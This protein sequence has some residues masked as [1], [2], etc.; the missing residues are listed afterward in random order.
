R[1]RHPLA[2]SR[3][4]GC[5]NWDGQSPGPKGRP[6]QGLG[7]SLEATRHVRFQQQSDCK[8]RYRDISANWG[9]RAVVGLGGGTRPVWTSVTNSGL[10]IGIGPG[11][12]QLAVDPW[13]AVTVRA[14]RKAIERGAYV[15]RQ[16]K[17]APPER[18]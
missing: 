11:L 2:Q 7:G 17:K 1:D 16:R 13:Q 12:R 3:R 18:G 9:R 15:A 10:G 6:G 14:R 8:N 4:R 5:R